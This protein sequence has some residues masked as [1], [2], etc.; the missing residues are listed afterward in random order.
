MS[1]PYIDSL[2]NNEKV[3]VVIRTLIRLYLSSQVQT[4]VEYKYSLLHLAVGFEI[5]QASRLSEEPHTVSSLASRLNLS[6]KT[7]SRIVRELMKFGMVTQRESPDDGRVRHLYA[8]DGYYAQGGDSI[9]EGIQA[10]LNHAFGEQWSKLE[11]DPQMDWFPEPGLYTEASS[12]INNFRRH[13]H[14]DSLQARNPR[15]SD[16]DLGEDI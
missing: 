4:R 12:Q 13:F 16:R 15:G 3:A 1:N 14:P 7:A 11:I 2:D 8:S 5:E 10:V 6:M 9:L